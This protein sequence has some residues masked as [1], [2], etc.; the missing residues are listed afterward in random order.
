MKKLLLLIIINGSLSAGAA[1]EFY[2]S[3]PGSKAVGIVQAKNKKKR[4]DEKAQQNRLKKLKSHKIPNC[5]RFSI[6]KSVFTG[7]CSRLSL[8]Q[9]LGA[10]ESIVIEYE[11][12]RT[13]SFESGC[14]NPKNYSVE[15]I[16][17]GVIESRKIKPHELTGFKHIARM[18]L[19]K[20]VTHKED[21]ITS[22]DKARFSVSSNDYHIKEENE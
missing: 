1:W 13:G 14:N 20:V 2:T 22:W 10:D 5:L 11:N 19:S 16:A 8:R 15:T 12:E 6:I 17:K 7:T 21:G 18:I 9:D 3:N 4:A